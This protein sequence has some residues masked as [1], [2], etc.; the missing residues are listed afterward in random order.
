MK[1][2]EGNNNHYIIIPLV[3][4]CFLHFI[5]PASVEMQKLFMCSVSHPEV[6]STL[7]KYLS[8]C[9]LQRVAPR[10]MFNPQGIQSD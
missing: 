7:L 10:M 5:V 3:T 9:L 6:S 8:F 1:I 4:L 2:T